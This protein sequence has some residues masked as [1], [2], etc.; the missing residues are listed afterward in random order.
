MTN[1]TKEY[2]NYKQYGAKDVLERLKEEKNEINEKIH[3]INVLTIISVL[4]DL[5]NEPDFK[6]YKAEFIMVKYYRENDNSSN[7]RIEFK[8]EYG[9]ELYSYDFQN[10]LVP[11]EDKM[12]DIF[13]ILKAD[14][15]FFQPY[16]T[17]GNNGGEFALNNDGLEEM[18][19]AFLN[20]NL[21]KSL[22]YAILNKQFIK[23]NVKEPLK[24]KI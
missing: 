8:D 12:H 1:I 20:D 11:L 18:K 21:Q 22:A 4:K 15:K 10:R 9:V 7:V 19:K 24:P 14:M 6:K 13:N 5:I 17:D 23:K 2:Q 16:Y 3:I